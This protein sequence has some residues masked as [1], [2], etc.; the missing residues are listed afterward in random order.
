MHLDLNG[1]QVSKTLKFDAPN[2]WSLYLYK[3]EI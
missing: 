1:K 2:M 3:N